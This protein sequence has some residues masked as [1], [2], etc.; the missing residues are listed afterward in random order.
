MRRAVVPV[1]LTIV[2]LAVT[3]YVADPGRVADALLHA[4]PWVLLLA[5]AF[6]PVT[7]GLRT[8]RWHL[9]ARDDV[10]DVTVRESWRSYLAGLTLAVVTPLSAGEL[11]RGALLGRGSRARLAGLTLADK[12]V[13]LS[14]ILVLGAVG[15]SWALPRTGEPGRE[16]LAW[17]AP[18]LVVGVPLCWFVV[19]RIGARAFQRAPG[20][21]SRLA[22]AAAEVP[23]RTFTRIVV[24]SGIGFA[25]HMTQSW[26]LLAAVTDA[27]PLAVIGVW[28]AVTLATIL[29]AFAGGV[30]PR[31]ASAAL[32]L[33]LVGVDPAAA[34]TAA[35]LQF[36]VVMLLPAGLGCLVLG[37]SVL[38]P[39]PTGDAESA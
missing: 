10:P 25:V 36:A 1:A 9:L 29:P 33:P 19:R 4:D 7:L 14:W 5:T 32:L 15:L 38:R 12:L 26:Y 24:L 17:V 30:G 21:V 37:R 39:V 31:E 35:F 16:A 23:A 8:A 6:T 13:D 11:G 20:P 2:T 27:P 22:T 3:L 18:G 34:A 28:P